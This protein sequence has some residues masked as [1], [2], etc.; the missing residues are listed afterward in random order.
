MKATITYQ[1]AKIEQIAFI[2][3]LDAKNDDTLFFLE[4]ENGFRCVLKDEIQSI[5]IE[6]WIVFF[7]FILIK[8][9]LVNWQKARQENL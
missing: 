8:R 2:K 6:P 3:V 5:I 7:A 1:N 9:E 4:T